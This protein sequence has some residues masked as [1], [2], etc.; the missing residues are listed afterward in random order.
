MAFPFYL[1]FISIWYFH[2]RVSLRNCLLTSGCRVK[3]ARTYV[4]PI[5]PQD[6]P[7]SF[8]FISL[9]E[10]YLMRSTSH[11]APRCAIFLVA[12]YFFLLRPKYFLYENSIL[13]HPETL[14]FAKRERISFTQ[15]DTRSSEYWIF[16]FLNSKLEDKKLWSEW[17]HASPEVSLRLTLTLQTWWI[18]WA[19]NNANKWQMGFNLAFKEL[20]PSCMQIWFSSTVSKYLRFVTFFKLLSEFLSWIYC[21]FCSQDTIM[22]SVFLVFTFRQTCSVSTARAWAFVCTQ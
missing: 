17:P 4:L 2:L 11:E 7:I 14:F 19:P 8:S 21:T 12:C 20:I 6:A 22:Y 9:P 1:R 18:W 5:L 16:I 3:R 13:K 15:Q 10:Y